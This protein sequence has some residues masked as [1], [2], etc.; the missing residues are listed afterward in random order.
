[1]GGV[2]TMEGLFSDDGMLVSACLFISICG[3]K[4]SVMAG[5][6]IF[7]VGKA[8]FSAGT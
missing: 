1:M 4:V 6:S 8:I 5:T 3:T 7:S 2:A